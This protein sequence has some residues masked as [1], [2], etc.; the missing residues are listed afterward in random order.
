MTKQTP[1]PMPADTTTPADKAQSDLFIA[2]ARELE[3]DESG[4]LF[5]KAF[6]IVAPPTSQPA[7]PK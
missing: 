1:A 2:V 6:G 3:S 5:E 4:A 7:K